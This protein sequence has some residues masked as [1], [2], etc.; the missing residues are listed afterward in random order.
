MDR[1]PRLLGFC[2][3]ALAAQSTL[4]TLSPVRDP[5]PDLVIAAVLLVAAADVPV[6]WGVAVAL[7]VGYLFDLLSGCPVGLHSLIF[8]A[9][10]LVGRWIRRRFFLAGALFEITLA[11][12]A[13]W[14]GAAAVLAFRILGQGREFGD[15]GGVAASTLVRSLLT[16]VAAPAVFWVGDRL[17]AGRRSS[18]AARPLARGLP[19]GS[20]PA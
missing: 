17:T 6:V 20:P 2:L 18:L 10:Y 12:G 15:V 13:V 14:F 19:P 4:A 11:A 7:V 16:A 5:L 3:L 8:Q 1:V 9:V